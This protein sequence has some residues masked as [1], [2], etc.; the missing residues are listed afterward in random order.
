MN[1]LLS[2]GLMLIPLG[3]IS[4]VI[5]ASRRKDPMADY[6]ANTRLHLSTTERTHAVP[7]DRC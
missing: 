3:V 2:F 7:E 6:P 5:L 1:Y 4:A